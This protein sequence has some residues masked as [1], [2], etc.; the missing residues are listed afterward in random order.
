M[1]SVGNV[2]GVDNTKRAKKSA[3]VDNVV[4]KV[5]P[6]YLSIGAKEVNAK[7]DRCA[8]VGAERGTPSPA[9]ARVQCELTQP[10]GTSGIKLCQC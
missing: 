5:A 10:A 6:I 8:S 4:D 7:L 1:R 9:L 3:S 2:R